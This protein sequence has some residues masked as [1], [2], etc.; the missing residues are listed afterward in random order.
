VIVRV[1]RQKQ[2]R[3]R[4]LSAL[5]SAP[6]TRPSQPAR[7]DVQDIVD[8]RRGLGLASGCDEDGGG[9]RGAEGIAALKHRGQRRHCREERRGVT[10]GVGLNV[11][12]PIASLALAGRPRA[13]T[14]TRSA[15]AP[16]GRRRL[17]TGVRSR[18][19]QG[20]RPSGPLSSRRRRHRS[21]AR[22]APLRTGRGS[23]RGAMLGRGTE[24]PVDGRKDPPSCGAR[25]R[26]GLRGN[27]GDRRPIGSDA[28][29]ASMVLARSG[30]APYDRRFARPSVP[31][32]AATHGR[33]HALVAQAAPPP[34]KEI[35][36]AAR[37]IERNI[38][39]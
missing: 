23:H 21:G 7:A 4:A 31:L 19:A 1:P 24:A 11:S 14:L 25:G 9:V 33:S 6:V 29:V 27:A 35:Y 15:C 32:R 28:A 17:D 10:R 5:V 34:R 30:H 16:A 13:G 3:D 2:A 8:L 38:R 22:P 37:T 26:D 18:P 39:C 20:V 36:A 12:G